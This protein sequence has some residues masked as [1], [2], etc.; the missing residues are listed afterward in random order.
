MSFALLEAAAILGVLLP[1]VRL[2]R[3]S[4]RAPDLKLRITL[5]PGAGLPMRVERALPSE[6]RRPQ[7]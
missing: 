2:S 6:N 1:A 4:E 7:S 3:A 5:R